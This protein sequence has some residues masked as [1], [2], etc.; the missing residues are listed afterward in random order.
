MSHCEGVDERR[1]GEEV[2][3]VH[4]SK[5]NNKGVIIVAGRSVCGGGGERGRWI[6]SGQCGL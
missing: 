2:V 5:G 6:G 1:G 4:Q 3:E